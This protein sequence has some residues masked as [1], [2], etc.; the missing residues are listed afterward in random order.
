MQFSRG[1]RAGVLAG[2]M[3][4]SVRLWKRPQVRVGGRY[5]V[6]PGPQGFQLVMFS[7]HV[8]PRSRLIVRFT[9]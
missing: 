4:L 9:I 1:L 3:T 5:R 6:G 8:A 7:G 2:D